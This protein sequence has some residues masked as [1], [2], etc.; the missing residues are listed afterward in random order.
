MRNA[1]VCTYRVL[2][3]RLRGGCRCSDGRRLLDG[4]IKFRTGEE[5]DRTLYLSI[6]RYPV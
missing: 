5:S 3:Q 2:S 4:V 1:K 6:F